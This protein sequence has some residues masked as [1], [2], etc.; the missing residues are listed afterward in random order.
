MDVMQAAREQGINPRA[1][2]D[3]FKTLVNPGVARSTSTSS[4]PSATP[5]SSNT[6]ST[7]RRFPSATRSS[8]LQQ[9]LGYTQTPL[10]DDQENQLIALLAQNQPQRAGNGTAGNDHRGRRRPNIYSL[11]N[12]GGTARVTNE[13]IAQAQGILTGRSSAPSSRS[14]LSSRPSSRCS[15]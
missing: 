8:S 9:A 7:S 12:G 14:R 4:R 5:A 6:S 1:D 2:P 15:R 13:A 10:T 11:M 3:G